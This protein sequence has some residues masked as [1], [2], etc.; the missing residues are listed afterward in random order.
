M[1]KLGIAAFKSVPSQANALD[2]Q[3]R[4]NKARAHDSQNARENDGADNFALFRPTYRVADH[5]D[6]PNRRACEHHDE[7]NRSV[8][9]E[10]VSQ[11]KFLLSV[12]RPKQA[13]AA[14]E[15]V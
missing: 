13:L 14:R 3:P 15:V 9:I 11:H 12:D 6:R 8:G 5:E 4:A 2:T 1:P 7:Q 10:P